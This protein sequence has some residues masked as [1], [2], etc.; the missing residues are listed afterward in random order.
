M[1]RDWGGVTLRS[2]SGDEFS[3]MEPLSGGASA[4]FRSR[5]QRRPRTRMYKRLKNVVGV[6]ESAMN[7]IVDL[8]F[9]GVDARRMSF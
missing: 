6:Q 8:D 9:K 3:F 5:T 7:L 2:L 4:A 1:P